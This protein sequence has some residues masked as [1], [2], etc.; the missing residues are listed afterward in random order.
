MSKSHRVVQGIVLSSLLALLAAGCGG[1]ERRKIGSVCADGDQC[2]TGFCYEFRCL[3][4]DADEDSDGLINKVEAALGTDPF[5]RDTDGDGIPDLDEVGDPTAPN[6]T[7]GD[8]TPE[9]PRHDAL[10][11]AIADADGDCIPDQ[12][13]PRDDEP[14]TDPDVVARQACL[15]RGVCRDAPVDAECEQPAE[16]SDE[17][18]VLHCDYD[19]V[20]DFEEGTETLCDLKDNNCDG[21]VDEGLTYLEDGEPK[22]LGRSCR[23]VGACSDVEGVVECRPSDGATICSV[24]AGGSEFAGT[25][26]EI[27]CNEV[28]DD[29]DGLTD[30][31]VTWTA[32]D[33]EDIA[34][35]EPC[36][37]PGVCGLVE[38]HVE[39][40]PE[41]D[42][43]TCSTLPGGSEDQSGEEVCDGADND[44]DEEVDEGIEWTSPA[45]EVLSV[46][47]GCGTGACEGGTVVCQSGVPTCSTLG[48][49]T[50]GL[51]QC[52]G[53]DDDCDG[54]TDEPDGL[55]LA[56]P[57]QGVCADLEPAEV[58]CSES[59]LVVCSYLGVEGYEHQEEVSCNGVDDDCD[60]STDEDLVSADGLALGEACQGHGV[61][62]GSTGTV[63]CDPDPPAGGTPGAV[64]SADLEGTPEECDGLDNDCDGQTDEG[65]APPEDLG[66]SVEGLCAGYVDI[67]PAC[68]DA[69]WLCP[70]EED[71]S[72]EPEEATCDGLDNDCDGLVDDGVPKV[73][74]G[75][76]AAR[77]DVQPPDRQ[78]W[79]AAVPDDGRPVIYGGLQVRDDLDGSLLG[80][81]LGDTWRY[82]AEIHEW[83]RLPTPADGG[84]G[85]RAGHATAWEPTQGVVL[86]HGGF[87]TSS[88]G[89]T[90]SG[91]DPDQVGADLPMV[92]GAWALD[93]ETG[94]WEAVGQEPGLMRAHHSLVALG[95]GRVVL[96]GG[97]GF[98]ELPSTLVGTLEPGG[99]DE[100]AWVI[101]WQTDTPQASPRRAH[102]AVRDPATGRVVLVGGDGPDGTTPP[103]A[104]AWSGDPEE[105]WVVLGDEAN[106]PGARVAPSTTIAGGILFVLG[107]AAPG[108]EYA[109][110]D[111]AGDGWQIPVDGGGAWGPFDPP[112]ALGG[113]AGAVTWTEG[114]STL[115]LAGGAGSLPVSH[116]RT[117]TRDLG[118]G[119]WSAGTRW[120]GPAPRVGGALSVRRDTGETWLIGGQRVAGGHPL[121]DVWRYVDG[122]WEVAAEA[123]L[124][125][126][127]VDQ[128]RPSTRGAAAV[129]DPVGER[130]LVYGGVDVAGEPSGV[131]W[132]WVP[133][134]QT[135][136]MPDAQGD[137]PP[138]AREAVFAVDE[139]GTTAWLLAGQPS[140]N[141]GFGMDLTLH[142]LELSTLTWTQVWASGGDAP[143]PWMA[144]GLVGGWREG[145]EVT[146]LGIEGDVSMWR[147]IEGGWTEEAF[148]QIFLQDFLAGAHDPASGRSLLVARGFDQPTDA[149]PATLQVDHAG[150]TIEP[151]AAEGDWP[152]ALGGAA[153][154]VHPSLGALLFGG[155][156]DGG[157]THAGWITAGQAC[158]Q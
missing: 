112:D 45:G 86:V 28:D 7:D 89:Q 133:G 74:T 158:P 57:S 143:G 55:A 8:S 137:K 117:F 95:D 59:D 114:E 83:E 69:S 96:H 34:W 115:R 154:A 144:R 10:E 5:S 20:A 46:G 75:A 60:G 65:A 91:L 105:G 39:C 100:P 145:L 49:A 85:P 29:C 125:G 48:E 18:P 138:A 1:D 11:S 80:R 36:F 43:G 119:A 72:F 120:S 79:R 126:A 122:A 9:D 23:G 108:D 92:P 77:A 151:L 56:C 73:F 67:P 61:C 6:D 50:D 157:Y 104:E 142:R 141:G 2:V 130:I 78:R 38:G 131:L 124:P 118:A 26:A 81:A 51:E 121:Q 24:N 128:T 35:G 107:G 98:D 102:A 111:L 13:D 32:P 88:G 53:V 42:G 150:A 12:Q 54:D 40:A 31:G 3:D 116:R 106:Q 37:A 99:V 132:A 155:A 30:D 68:V 21:Q 134:E 123:T 153:A 25:D 41:G 127:G 94:A 82:D 152:S 156:G 33:G 27:Q 103:L 140:P 93:P 146:V 84:P 110:G 97:V 19:R 71:P 58:F 16:G 135:F 15:N 87:T 62:A 70:Y 101:Q 14:E 52:N 90:L 148:P 136:K 47:D 66:C 147:W 44:C 139:D 64:C 17:A 22:G 113:Q 4:P 76:L 63:V 149:P 129:W 109:V